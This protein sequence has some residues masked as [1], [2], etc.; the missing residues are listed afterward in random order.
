[1]ISVIAALVGAV[2]GIIAESI[3]HFFRAKSERM[4][5]KIDRAVDLLIELEFAFENNED[6][7]KIKRL[8]EYCRR[9]LLRALRI[10]SAFFQK[11]DNRALLQEF[12]TILEH[13][14][15]EKVIVD[16]LGDGK[17][18][19]REDYAATNREIACK[20]AVFTAKIEHLNP[21]F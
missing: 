7:R 4:V 19:P 13:H 9:A 10:R 18:F 21:H 1:M 12:D 5:D 20:L 16:L 8:S 17:G 6:A 15:R 2:V 14:S 11:A 3:A